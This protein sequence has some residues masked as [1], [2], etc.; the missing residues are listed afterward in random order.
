MSTDLH[1]LPP[2]V[3]ADVGDE[4]PTRVACDTEWCEGTFVRYE[5]EHICRDCGHVRFS[6]HDDTPRSM[7]DPWE[8]FEEQRNEY[9]GFYGRDRVRMVGG[10]LRAY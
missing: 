6:D 1:Q 8:W 3:E 4:E 10:F 7:R 9:S 5:G 2:V